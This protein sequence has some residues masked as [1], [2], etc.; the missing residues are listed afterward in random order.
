M[1]GRSRNECGQEKRR[2]GRKVKQKKNRMKEK[3]NKRKWNKRK[4]NERK[5][6]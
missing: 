4:W 3:W 6:E 1:A 5:R 2:T